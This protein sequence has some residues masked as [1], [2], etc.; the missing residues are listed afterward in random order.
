L[1]LLW[2]CLPESVRFLARRAPDAARL[3]RILERLGRLP[4]GWAGR[5]E[6]P[7]DESDGTSPLRQILGAELRGGTLL[8]WA[9]FFMGLLI[10]YLLTNW[11]PTLIGGTGFSLGEAAT[12]SAMFQLGGTLGALLLGSAMDRFDAHRV[13]SLA[14]VGG[15]LFILGI[16]SLYH[17]F[18][19]LALCVAGVGF[20][21]SGSQVGA[22][23]LAAV[24]YPTRSRATGVSWAL[25]LGRIGSIVGSLSGGALLG[26]GLGFSGILALLVIPALL[27]AVAVHR[28]GRRRARP[29]PTTL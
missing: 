11:L 4:D 22:N 6:L 5:L 21:I 19:L 13:L 18:A 29:S 26:L 8:L 14:Y 23:A 24:F 15:A 16:A 28:L 25:G 27:A 12:I 3:R 1:P 2:A 10:I 20:C 9:T 7:A 17:S